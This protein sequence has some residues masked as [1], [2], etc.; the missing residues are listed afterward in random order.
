MVV[1]VVV[2][3]WS[4]LHVDDLSSNP[5][6]IKIIFLTYCTIRLNESE[7]KKDLTNRRD[8]NPPHLDF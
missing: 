6:A 7:N 2:V 5:A 1:A 4:A 3:K 8:M